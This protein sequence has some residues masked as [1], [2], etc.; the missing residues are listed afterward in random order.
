MFS[1]NLSME[2]SLGVVADLDGDAVLLRQLGHVLLDVV[3][4]LAVR[5]AGHVQKSVQVSADG[6]ASLKLHPDGTLETN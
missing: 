6:E 1:T 4:D 5:P 3:D 2:A